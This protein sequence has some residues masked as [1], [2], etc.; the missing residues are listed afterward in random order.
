[1]N[2]TCKWLGPAL[3]SWLGPALESWSRVFA[4]RVCFYRLRLRLCAKTEKQV[5]IRGKGGHAAA[6]IGMGVVDPIV[7]AT[8]IVQQLQTIVSRDLSPME[9]GIVSVTM[10]HAGAA[11]NVVPDTVV[12]GGHTTEP[13]APMHQA[14]RLALHYAHRR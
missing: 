9:E 12:I 2:R 1:M 13:K 4:S 7:A 6:G 8:A 5:T 11:Y 10:I 3:E 14:P